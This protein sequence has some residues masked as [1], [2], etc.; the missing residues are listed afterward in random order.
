MNFKNNF[1]DLGL[2]NKQSIRYTVSH[3]ISSFK[4]FPLLR[5]R[6]KIVLSL[7]LTFSG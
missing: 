3:D 5:I 1:G 2:I 6:I 7:L 4:I